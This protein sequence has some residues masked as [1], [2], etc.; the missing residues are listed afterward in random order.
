MTLY[1]C[2]LTYLIFEFFSD[3][4]EDPPKGQEPK[5]NGHITSL[6]VLRSHRKL[7]IAT[8]LMTQARTSIWSLST[9]LNIE[10]RPNDPLF[11]VSR[12]IHG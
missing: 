1:I 8:K 11:T 3:D 5:R 9:L 7:G 6:A 10:A 12:K 2:L 4:E